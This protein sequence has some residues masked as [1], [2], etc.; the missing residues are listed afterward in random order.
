M[1]LSCHP[2]ISL[3]SLSTLCL[4]GVGHEGEGK[5]QG[6]KEG[7]AAHLDSPDDSVLPERTDTSPYSMY[8]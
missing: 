2:T 1:S 6:T 3:T 8:M 5:G 7:D 4:V